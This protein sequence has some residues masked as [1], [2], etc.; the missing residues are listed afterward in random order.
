MI[1]WL[2]YI[3]TL[4]ANDSFL[5]TALICF[6]KI[7]FLSPKMT[8]IARVLIFFL[9]WSMYYNIDIKERY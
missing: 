2:F 3:T 7:Y 8:G 9:I 5:A 1:R 4:E 6:D